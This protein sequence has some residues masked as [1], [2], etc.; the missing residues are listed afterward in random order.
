MGLSETATPFLYSDIAST[1]F[2]TGIP[3]P[4]SGPS[5]VAEGFVFIYVLIL[6]LHRL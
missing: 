2:A 3:H 1:Q 5:G 4:N 6:M